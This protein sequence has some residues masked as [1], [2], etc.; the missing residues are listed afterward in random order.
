M[1]GDNTMTEYVY[2]RKGTAHSKITIPVEGAIR[3]KF[4]KDIA[5]NQELEDK[6]IA[7]AEQIVEAVLANPEKP[8]MT[9]RAYMKYPNFLE[10]EG[11]SFTVGGK[12][13]PNWGMTVPF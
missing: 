11:V 9:L 3:I 2:E 10:H 8:A 4:G 1:I 7:R 12:N 6:V 13:T 5:G